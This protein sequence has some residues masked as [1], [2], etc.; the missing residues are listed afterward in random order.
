MKQ[1]VQDRI[2]GLLSFMAIEL[3]HIGDLVRSDDPALLA[4]LTEVWDLHNK[5]W[6]TLDRK[7]SKKR[8]NGR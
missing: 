5:L 3:M 2:K 1:K 7:K 8:S 4:H 6:R